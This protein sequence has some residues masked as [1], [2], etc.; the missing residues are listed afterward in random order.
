MKELFLFNLRAIDKRWQ[1]SIPATMIINGNKKVKAFF[2][3]P[4]EKGQLEFYLGEFRFVKNLQLTTYH[5]L[6]SCTF[7]ISYGNFRKCFR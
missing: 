1:G 2:E 4:L 5:L 3:T 6:L 7:V